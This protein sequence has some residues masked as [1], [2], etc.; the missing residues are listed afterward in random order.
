VWA[1]YP[2]KKDV[3]FQYGRERHLTMTFGKVR[4]ISIRPEI[5]VLL[6]CAR[7]SIDRETA[8]R[9]PVLV[10]QVTDWD[11]LTRIAN[12]HGVLPLLYQSLN[13]ICPDA[14]PPVRMKFLR[15][16]FQFNAKR[17]LYLMAVLLKLLTA[18]KNNGIDAIPFKGAVLGH[19]IY[20]NVAL[21]QFAD[22]DI[23]VH[24]KDLAGAGEILRLQGF[25]YTSSVDEI[26][27][28]STIPSNG[29]Q[30]EKVTALRDNYHVFVRDD[31][32]VRVDLQWRMTHELFSFSL[33]SEN[34]WNRVQ[35]VSLGGALVSTFDNETLLL[36][37]C[38]H[39]CKHSWQRLKWICDVAQLI[40]A[41]EPKDR[42]PLIQRTLTE[43]HSRRIVYAGL[44]LAHEI[45]GAALPAKAVSEIRSDSSLKSV[46]S[47]VRNALFAESPRAPSK[48]Q[49]VV[50]YL[51]IMESWG[52]R[53]GYCGQ[54]LHQQVN[55]TFAPFAPTS[56]ERALLPLPKG[57]GFL[58]YGLR[59]L[60]LLAKY[61]IRTFSRRNYRN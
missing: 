19:S 6:A 12:F 28:E 33:D 11:Y 60:R 41:T 16:C 49:R 30:A 46:L 58:Y 25:A 35:D 15:D 21:R 42:L 24:R 50:F 40:E 53:L 17:N 44:L 26:D 55:S 27:D 29:C 1:D 7:P 54:Y 3:I 22:L 23:L 39:G 59:P 43:N 45:L 2:G 13:Q 36:I 37:L 8:V 51:K 20:G 47:S 38:A 52:E 48:R 5:E 31:G 18:L 10:S 61:G 32:K 56:I 57:L 4:A 34:L 9:F 14:V